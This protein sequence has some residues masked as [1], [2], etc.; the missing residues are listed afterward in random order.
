MR[1]PRKPRRETS[2]IFFV[3]SGLQFFVFFVF[4]WL[5]LNLNPLSAEIPTKSV[6]RNEPHQRASS[7]PLASRTDKLPSRLGSGTAP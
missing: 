3:C 7:T 1:E 4:S 6:K 2:L 5:A